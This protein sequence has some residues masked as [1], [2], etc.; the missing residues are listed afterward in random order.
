MGLVAVSLAAGLGV[1]VDGRAAADD[2]L[3]Q[4]RRPGDGF[5]DGRVA[6]ARDL[7]HPVVF[8]PA[9]ASKAE[10]MT[11][12]DA[13][14]RQ[15]RVALGL[16]PWPDRTPL[17]AS[18]RGRIVRDGYT[19]ELVA[20][21]SVPGHWVTGSLYRPIGR[22]GR[23]PAVLAPHGHW[24]GGRLQE[25]SLEDARKEM[26]SGAEQT[27][28]GARYPLQARPAMLA[29][30][31]VIV[32]AWDLVGYADSTAIPHREGFT[33]AAAELR[34]Q[35]F[36]GL[37]MWNAVRAVDWLA[38]LPDV[39]PA[40]IG[41]NGASGGGT[42]SLLLAAID[43]RIAA[44]VPA[45][46]VGGNMQ[47]GCVCENASLL[48]LGT[49]NIELTALA[50]PTPLA[51]VAANDWTVDFM[52][53]G[54]PELQKIYALMGAPDAVAGRHFDFPHNDNQL[55]R[56]YAY[57]WF[58]KVFE[59]GAPEPV[60][61]KPFV[62][63]PPAEL[64]VFDEAHPR[65][66][67]ERDAAGVRKA[68]SEASDRQLRRLASKR[69]TL[70]PAM[71]PGFETALA[72]AMPARVAPVQGSFREL[73]G[74]G[75]AVHQS[76]LARPG[77]PARVP[78]IG[79]VPAGWKS[80]PVVVWVHE[81]GKRAAFEADGRTP[82]PEV[83]ALLAKGAA[84]MAPDVFLTGENGAIAGRIRVKNDETYFGYNTG[85]NRSVLAER[86][87][88]VRTVIA[89]ARGI[90]GGNVAVVGRGR[91]GTWVLAA[92]AMTGDAVARTVVDLGGFDFDQVRDVK[93]EQLLPGAVKY[94]GVRGLA[95][96]A[97]EGGV[98]IFG[99]PAAPVAPW[100]ALPSSV[101]VHQAP[102]SA[103][104][105]VAAALKTP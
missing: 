82:V 32:F 63:V 52:T 37:Q 77:S 98:T 17:N 72:D 28:E 87:A 19:V 54:L 89:F 4:V 99:M 91:A 41:V 18:V 104:E 12:A 57:A 97:T 7:D 39:D 56:E 9:F 47:G 10:W 27:L 59:L 40:R 55:S 1:A 29:R 101:T 48:R 49:N 88:D 81:Q 6:A 26:A 90:G 33:D 80:G 61:E 38:G 92:R 100:I 8:T 35:N 70:E 83:R 46:M 44:A 20:F 16:W 105:L 73:A 21:E 23:L 66:A 43:D 85:Y 5:D 64:H 51:A 22:S 2:A 3:W 76:V 74:D 102:A 103:D 15:V 94:G 60:R 45:V 75:F 78:G 58:N 14:R 31:G 95:S 50:A 69:E 79:L 53:K 62:P 24:P 25:R 84:V 71:R 30:M 93:D 68:M 13:L 42:Q 65:P 86:A 36:L 11:R 96:L 67:S 34:Q